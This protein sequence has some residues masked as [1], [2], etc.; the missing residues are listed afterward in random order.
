LTNRHTN[1]SISY[2]IRHS[3]EFFGWGISTSRDP[4]IKQHVMSRVVRLVQYRVFISVKSN[5]CTLLIRRYWR[6]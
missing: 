5:F 2:F 3:A 1:V 4:Y 6:E